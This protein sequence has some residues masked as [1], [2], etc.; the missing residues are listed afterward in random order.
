MR[1]GSMVIVLKPGV[2]DVEIEDVCDRIR[3]MCYQPHTI[4]GVHRTVVGAIGDDRGW[5]RLQ[6]LGSLPYVEQVAPVL[7]PFKLASREMRR[8]PT[9]IEAGGV[10]IGGKRVVVVAGP[11]SVESREQ[12]LEIAKQVKAAGARMLRGGAFKPRTS[13]YSFQGLGCDG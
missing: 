3:A 8:E 2:T 10:T 6:S 9:E 13:P 5:E 12:M 4:R 7:Q 1:E 11:C